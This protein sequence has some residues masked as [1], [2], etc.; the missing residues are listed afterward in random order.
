MG[1]HEHEVPALVETVQKRTDGAYSMSLYYI[2][3]YTAYGIYTWLNTWLYSLSR[4]MQY[5]TK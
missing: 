3:Y 5:S 4:H 2:L 1:P